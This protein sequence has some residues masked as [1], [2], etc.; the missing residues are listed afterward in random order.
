MF[1]HIKSLLH[2]SDI[3]AMGILSVQEI[4]ELFQNNKFHKVLK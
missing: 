3:H 4:D 2:Q 1:D